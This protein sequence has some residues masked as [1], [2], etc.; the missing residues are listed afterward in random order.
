MIFKQKHLPESSKNFSLT[1]WI[2]QLAP[3]PVFHCIRI[4][5]G[6]RCCHLPEVKRG[7]IISW[8]QT[9]A[10]QRFVLPSSFPY[11]SGCDG[12]N[13]WE[14]GAPKTAPLL[15]IPFTFSLKTSH[16]SLPCQKSRHQTGVDGG[17]CISLGLSLE[18]FGGFVDLVCKRQLK[19]G[20]R[21]VS[22]SFSVK[23]LGL[24]LMVS[25]SLNPIRTSLSLKI[26]FPSRNNRRK[27]SKWSI[28]LQNS[29]CCT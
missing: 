18:W 21:V 11:S 25:L 12:G 26:W 8:E 3:L 24:S 9:E 27:N 10:V 15:L 20:T 19:S 16:Y 14:I 29:S 28:R 1:P 5:R 13:S 23:G 17:G 2:I 7:D 6:N 22:N 4:L